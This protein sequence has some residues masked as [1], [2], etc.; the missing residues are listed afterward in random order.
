[1]HDSGLRAV[2]AAR[3]IKAL[4]DSEITT[5]ETFMV[6]NNQRWFMDI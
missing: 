4:A 6:H 1:M 3:I 2:D 5:I